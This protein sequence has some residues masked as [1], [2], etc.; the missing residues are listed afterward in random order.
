MARDCGLE[1]EKYN[2]AFVSLWPG[3]VKT[4]TVMDMID[5]K[6]QDVN[7][8]VQPIYKDIFLLLKLMFVIFSRLL[9]KKKI[10]Y[11]RKKI[12]S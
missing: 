2:V 8:Q 4:E 12:H 7:K 10:F 1:L 5:K 6:G 11:K 3:P 9:Q